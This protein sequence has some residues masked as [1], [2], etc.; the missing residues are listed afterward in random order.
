MIL[1]ELLIV[2]IIELNTYIY[3]KLNRKLNTKKYNIIIE[4][5]TKGLKKTN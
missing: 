5:N 2:I 3:R 4:L 1:R